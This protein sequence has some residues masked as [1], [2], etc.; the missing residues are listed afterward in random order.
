MGSVVI[1]SIDQI[2]IN[3]SYDGNI[4]ALCIQGVVV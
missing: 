2:I 4:V 3:H 1:I